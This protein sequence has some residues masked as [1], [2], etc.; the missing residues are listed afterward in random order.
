MTASKIFLYFCLSFILGIFI[1]SMLGFLPGSEVYLLL[2]GLILGIL[3]ISVFWKYK[4]FVIF[5][6]CILFLV[7]GIWRKGIFDLRIENSK[8]RILN[9]K[10][11]TAT[12]VG[13]IAEDPIIKEKSTSFVFNAEQINVNGKTSNISGKILITARKYPVYEYGDKLEITGNLKAPSED[14][15]GFNYKNYLLKD[16]IYSVISFPKIE[17]IS[18]NQGNNLYKYLFSFKN[19]LKESLNSVMSPP[20]AGILEALFFGDENNISND[21]KDKFNLTGVRHITAV[22]GM[23]ITI[24]SA[25]IL[26]FLLFL[27]FWRKQAF[28]ISVILIVFYI[29]MI[30][31]PASALRAGIMGILFLS[32]QYFGRLSFAPRSI[33]F[34]AAFM[35]LLN[36]L[37]LKLDVGF[38]LSFLAI[39]G[40]VYL[41]PH[42]QE[43][44][45]KIPNFLQL[46]YTLAATLSAQIFT[47]PVL[48]YNFG[49][50]SILSPIVNILIVPLFSLITILGFTFSFAGIF[51]PF[52]GQIISWPAWLLLTYVLK[53]IDLFSKIQ[54]V[55]KNISN[56]HWGLLLIFYSVSGFIIWRLQEKQKL[57]FLQY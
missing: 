48:I 26:N 34:A 36:P 30:G 1:S 56:M 29:L 22:S 51:L 45:Q 27:G 10:S 54:F 2:P 28:F 20:Q 50:I 35:L 44:F 57:K 55:S 7:L 5:G 46:R 16:G 47:L 52:L 53:V 8:L 6:F 37:L 12:L 32:A 18:K 3:L 19:K 4:K 13:V 42:F 38:Q 21:W 43:F 23:N 31:F 24:I 39:M 41:Q 49:R 14:I 33:I 17:L 9:D 40:L 11:E 25:L 15:N